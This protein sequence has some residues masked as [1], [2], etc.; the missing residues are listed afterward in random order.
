[1]LR[2]VHR[3]ANPVY[4]AFVPAALLSAG[5]FA[6]AHGYGWIGFISVL[7]SGLLWA[8]AYEK[9]GSLIPGMVAHALNNLLVCLAVM[10]LLR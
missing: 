1:M 8:W 6:V 9:T 3:S 7:W 4:C 10:A 2:N 5:V